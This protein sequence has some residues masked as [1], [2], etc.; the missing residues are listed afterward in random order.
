MCG[1]LLRPLRLK[2][3]V[4]VLFTIVA[5]CSASLLR[6]LEP[7]ASAA[8]TTAAKAEQSQQAAC[9]EGLRALKDKLR[10]DHGFPIPSDGLHTWEVEGGADSGLFGYLGTLSKNELQHEGA[11]T[12][13][14][15]GFNYGTSAYAFLCS[16]EAKV[17]SWDLGSH[18]YVQAASAIVSDEFPD[19]HHLELGDSR[20]TLGQAV[21]SASRGPLRA[22]RCDMVYVDG[23]HSQ[24]VAATDIA[25]FAKLSK[26]GA[27]VVVD[28]C[29]H[30][31]KG[32]IQP[33]TTAFELAVEAGHVL[34]EPSLAKQFSEGRS[35]CV[36]RFP[37]AAASTSFLARR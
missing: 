3:H 37:K 10:Q 20:T 8:A 16:T 17:Y 31:G 32:H 2:M 13:C 22:R 30:G 12:V 11:A 7:A 33:V 5:T 14:E 24:E 23:G 25:N 28:D 1:R 34:A 29:F 6:S 21:A 19:R 15:T 9:D 4:S 35:I 18:D 26:P 36:G 27:L